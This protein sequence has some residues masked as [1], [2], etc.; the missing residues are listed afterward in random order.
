MNLLGGLIVP[1]IE[2]RERIEHDQRPPPGRGLKADL[3]HFGGGHSDPFTC[4]EPGELRDLSGVLSV[5]NH[6]K[7]KRKTVLA[8][9]RGFRCFEGRHRGL[10][11]VGHFGTGWAK[12][13]CPCYDRERK[14]GSACYY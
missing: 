11:G 2:A 3:S 10:I 12:V 9:Q 13:F 6:K 1:I 5:Q 7:M 8:R 4:I 14:E